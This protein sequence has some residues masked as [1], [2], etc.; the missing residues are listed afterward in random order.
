MA[1]NKAF[2]TEKEINLLPIAINIM[3]EYGKN[4]ML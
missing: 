1:E 4:I 3:N 2:N